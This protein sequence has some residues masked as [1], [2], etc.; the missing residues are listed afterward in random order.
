MS[1]WCQLALMTD[2]SVPNMIYVT[3]YQHKTWSL[4]DCNGRRQNEDH[5]VIMSEHRQKI[6]TKPHA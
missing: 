3:E 4:A 1:A 6:R 5:P 2:H